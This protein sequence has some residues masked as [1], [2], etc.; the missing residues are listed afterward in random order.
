MIA[1]PN[2][3]YNNMT[4]L[5]LY[6]SQCASTIIADDAQRHALAHMQKTFDELVTA[7]A[8]QRGLKKYFHKTKSVQGFYLWGNV[9]VGKTMLM[10]LFY[11]NLPF[12]QKQ[13][14][15]FHA[16]MRWVHQQLKE[17]QGQ[18]NPLQTIVQ[19]LAKETLLLCLDELVV[20]DITDAMIL[21]N[22]FRALIANGV[23]LVMTSNLAPD[24][25]YKKGLQRPL[26][27][28]AIELIKTHSQVLHLQS[29]ADYRMRHLKNAGVYYLNDNDD[30]RKQLETL[31][32]LF[33]KEESP[34]FSPVTLCDRSVSVVK[35]ASQVI[36]FDFNSICHVPRSAHDYLEIARQY[37]TVIVSGIHL[38]SATINNTLL[39][40]RLI[41]ILY[42]MKI[43]FI[44]SAISPI[45]EMSVGEQM[46]F[47]FMR[48]RSRLKEMQSESYFM[49]SF[50]P[51]RLAG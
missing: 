46:Q 6:E 38:T 20:S 18:K 44:C 17:H 47:E 8:K 29:A 48:T 15:H 31:F 39:F 4:L 49:Q 16:F 21:A 27:L 50:L 45:E 2:N 11:N 24:D 40:M 7:A 1:P 32:G 5:S 3:L 25:L 26:F 19:S 43:R 42:D 14:I 23:C 9:G 10:D 12:A 30:T 22:L 51:E 37:P 36:W 28:P 33:A 34:Q 13:R 35:H 41:D